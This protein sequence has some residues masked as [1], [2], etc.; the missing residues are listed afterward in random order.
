MRTNPG[1]NFLPLP[2]IVSGGEL[3]RIS[4][5]LQVITAQKENTPTLIFDEVDTGIG[6]KT[7]DI[8]GQLLRRLGEKVQ[9]LCIT[10]LPTIAAKAHHHF[11]V[12]KNI[13]K[14]AATV[15][16]QALTPTQRIE[17][18][19][20]MLGGVKITQKTLAHAEELLIS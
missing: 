7:A 16:I 12:E 1:Q 17:E 9:V 18:I 10:H 4:L 2:K 15:T 14:N 8:V 6:G 5:A 13:H 3:S 19:A 11:K 20:R